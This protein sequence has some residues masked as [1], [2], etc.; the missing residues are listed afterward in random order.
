LNKTIPGENTDASEAK[1]SESGRALIAGL[2]VPAAVA[3]HNDT[4][5]VDTRHSS[6]AGSPKLKLS[7]EVHDASRMEWSVV[8]PVQA[9]EE[10]T[11]QIEFEVDV[12]SNLF[13]PHEPWE[14]FQ[15]FG[16]FA[17]GIESGA[18][19]ESIDALR[20]ETLST[21]SRLARAHDALIRGL[22]ARSALL[23]TGDEP[24]LGPAV[25]EAIGFAVQIVADAR[26]RLCRSKPG[27]SAAIATERALVDEY[28]SVRVLEFLGSV[29]RSI[30]IAAQPTAPEP[31][32]PADRQAGS[33]APSDLS[34]DRVRA[35]LVT[36][37]EHRE[38]AAYVSSDGDSP[39]ALERFVERSSHLK[40]HFQE[41]LFLEHDTY[42]VA[43]R[44]HHVVAGFVA[45]IASTWAFVW[46][47]AL[48]D[49]AMSSSGGKIGSGVVLFGAVLGL[50]YAAKDRIK[51]IGRNWISGRVHTLYAQ[52]ISRF[53]LPPKMRSLTRGRDC[54]ATVRESFG[55]T[56]LLCEDPL[57][58]E[59]GAQ[60]KTMRLGYMHRGKLTLALDPRDGARGIKF[61]FRQDLSPIF[62]RLD[63]AHREVP[64]LSG[65][66]LRFVEAPRYYR[67]PIRFR[68]QRGGEELIESGAIVVHKRGLV[69]WEQ[70]G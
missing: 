67:L 49:R 41:V 25:D 38:R 63:D 42:Q 69:R 50:V 17:E 16:R 51:E 56:E 39:S 47:I 27:E 6:F 60:Q 28:L 40:K 13:V 4:S 12:P 37:L 7:C 5:R 58:P 14:H 22:R 29:R 9:Q 62:P 55:K 34:E 24:L 35:F 20:R 30:S 15:C 61:V 26:G 19:A 10:S 68:V 48:T 64:V 53:R 66:V 8:L 44:I 70:G 2:R 59:S 65:G 54:L 31:H 36:E 1:E 11:Y 32:A 45:V 57:N 3:A 33:V 21:A 23:V 52:R 46:Q 43:E 18:S